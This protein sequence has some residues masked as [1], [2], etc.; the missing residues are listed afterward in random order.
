ML[1]H[2]E[3]VWARVGCGRVLKND[4]VRSVMGKQQ[5]ADKKNAYQNTQNKSV[6]FQPVRQRKFVSKPK[7]DD[8]TQYKDTDVQN[9]IIFSKNMGI[10][11]IK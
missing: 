10:N 8:N 6:R 3:C 2:S 7:A 5:K 11:I 1:W 9:K 4:T